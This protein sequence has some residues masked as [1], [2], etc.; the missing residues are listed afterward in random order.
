MIYSEETE[1][2]LMSSE[3]L[4]FSERIKFGNGDPK[5][6]VITA[7][8]ILDR[9]TTGSYW[10]TVYATDRGVVPLYS[11]IE[12]YIEVEDVNDNAPLTSEPIYYPAVMENSPKD[13]SVIQIQAEDPDSGSNEKL[14]YRIT[15]GNPQNFFAINIKTGCPLEYR[16]VVESTLACYCFPILCHF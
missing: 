3:T 5:Q 6:G 13:V 8:D 14:T 11:T 15:S 9:E 2:S 16:F 10:L 4:Q 12:V 1:A 7:A